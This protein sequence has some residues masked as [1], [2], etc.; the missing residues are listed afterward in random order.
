M[1]ILVSG[2]RGAL[3]SALV[4]RLGGDVV[5]Q[6]DLP[7]CDVSRAGAF[8]HAV[9]AARPDIVLHCA[10]MTD[11]D[12]CARDPERAF[13]INALGTQNVAQACAEAGAAMLYVSTN[14]VFDGAGRV[15]Y[16]E[17]DATNPINV[18]G[19]TKL[20]GEWY[21]AHLLNRCYIVRTS[22]IYAPGGRNFLHKI[23][24]QAAKGQAMRVVAD[25]TASPT[26]VADLAEAIALLI[27]TGR[28]GI[29]HLTNAGFCSRFEWAREALQLIGCENVPL[30]PIRRSDFVRPST[31]PE[32]TALANNLGAALGIRLRP[33]QA[34]LAEFLA[35]YRGET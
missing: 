33:W 3:G 1:R 8:R 34:A 12:G 20:A 35:S 29:Y 15:P 5:E 27:Q 30:T 22:W 11:V 7:D 10:A 17:F 21:A 4:A 2:S 23:L 18:Y 6:C 28:Y 14:E 19:R 32:F 24:S 9:S 25:E 13:Q 16:A 26:S 31:P